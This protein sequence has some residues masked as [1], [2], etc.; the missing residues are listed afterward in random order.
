MVLNIKQ[1]HTTA[2]GRTAAQSLC[3]NEEHES[4]TQQISGY[5][6]IQQRLSY[7]MRRFFVGLGTFGCA[8]SMK[9]SK[10]S[11]NTISKAAFQ[12]CTIFW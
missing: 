6:S 8:L 5:V 12:D 9:S 4:I 10:R 1:Y 11:S 3:I 7:L 2:E